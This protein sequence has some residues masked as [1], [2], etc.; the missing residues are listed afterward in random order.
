MQRKGLLLVLSLVLALGAGAFAQDKPVDQPPKDQ[1]PKE[2][3]QPPKEQPPKDQ[4][5][6]SGKEAGRSP[7]PAKAA[8]AGDPLPAGKVS[9]KNLFPLEDGRVWRY[10]LRTW[11][12]TTQPEE[13]TTPEV[14]ENEPPR[15]HRLEVSVVDSQKIDGKDAR[16]LEYRLDDE[17]SLREF[18]VEEANQVLCPMRVL[19]S[20]DHRHDFLLQPSQPTLQ[21]E[22]AVGTSWS[23]TGKVG[24]T[25]GKQKFEVLREELVRSKLRPEGF[26]TIV[27]RTTFTGDD[28]S[29]G[30][31][32]KWLSPGVGIVR[33]ETE[34]KADQQ[35]YRTLA[36]LTNVS[37]KKK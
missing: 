22:L 6:P 19:G 23:W 14:Q 37:D 1:P 2:Q 20:G 34:V 36:V 29:T 18:Y 11:L 35:V 12:S 30:V 28:E 26:E 9:R 16:C 15:I 3:P 13:G 32:T 21:G 25:S 7:D 31:S 5:A 33:E 4:P 8:P 24:P 27:L 10:E 17:P